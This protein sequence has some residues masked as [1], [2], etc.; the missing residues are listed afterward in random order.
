MEAV[1]INERLKMVTILA[2]PS[3]FPQEV[4]LSVLGKV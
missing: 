1:H 4:F 3:F 2:P